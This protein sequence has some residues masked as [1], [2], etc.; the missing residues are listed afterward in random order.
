MKH[1]QRCIHIPMHP[2]AVSGTAQNQFVG[3]TEKKLLYLVS[4]LKGGLPECSSKS[5]KARAQAAIASADFG[6]DL[7][8]SS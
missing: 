5:F 2:Q 8:Q 3:F 4:W 1:S 6:L 7:I